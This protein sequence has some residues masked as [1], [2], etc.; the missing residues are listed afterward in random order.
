MF[1]TDKLTQTIG[2]TAVKDLYIG[3][4]DWNDGSIRENVNTNIIADVYIQRIG[5]TV[6]ATFELSWFTATQTMWKNGVPTAYMDASDG[7]LHPYTTASQQD[8]YLQWLT[9]KYN[10][11][12]FRRKTVP[13]AGFLNLRVQKTITKYATVALY[14]NKLLDYLP[15]YEVDGIRIHRSASPYFGMEINLTI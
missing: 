7:Q 10:E 14:V 8:P 12:V 11:D 3:L 13:F 15:D 1:S 4:Y 9:F 2:N 6:S 5:L